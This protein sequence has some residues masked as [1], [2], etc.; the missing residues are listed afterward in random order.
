MDTL[1]PV[2]DAAGA[3]RGER[4]G[5][6]VVTGFGDVI[7][8]YAVLRSGC[9][10]L[11]AGFRGF[12]CLGGEDRTTFVQGM[13]SN[14]V[15]GLK[16]GE[17]VHAAILTVQG[18]VVTDLRVF[19]LDAAVVLDF[20]V[21]RRESG[22]E[23]LERYVVADDVEFVEPPFVPLVLLEGRTAAAVF[24]GAFGVAVGTLPRFA[25][26]DFTFAGTLLR[27]AAVTHSGEPGF[28]VAGP[29]AVAAALWE[30]ACGAGAVPVGADALE[31][32]RVEAGIPLVDADMDETYLAPEVGLADAISFRKGCYIGQEVVERVA[33]RGNVQKRLVGLRLDGAAAVPPQTALFGDGREVGFVTSCVVSP[34]LGVIAL[35]YARRGVWDPGTRVD[36]A[37]DGPARSATV[38]ELPFVVPGA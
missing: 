29:H 11:D 33:S 18:R 15:A 37:A 34:E 20:P 30:R 10:V 32:A 1:E 14:D 5:R 4:F 16:P 25:H 19:V 31:I 28:L 3:V 13:V 26:V 24:A 7:A 27:V 21:H 35:G 6:P 2:L 36:V 8:E 17:G 38:V 23:T 12:A 22:L 9:A